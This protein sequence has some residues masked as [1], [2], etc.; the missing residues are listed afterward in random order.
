MSIVSEIPWNPIRKLTI[1]VLHFYI[2]VATPYRQAPSLA[3]THLFWNTPTMQATS[4]KRGRPST[5]T[6]PQISLRLDHDLTSAID[7]FARDK[8]SRS[9]AIRG[10]LR[11][12]LIQHGYLEDE[13]LSEKTVIERAQRD[14]D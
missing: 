2:D 6:L 4:K 11:D 7:A 14:L 1:P 3:P 12:W 9:E 13:S 5:G 8:P 10:I